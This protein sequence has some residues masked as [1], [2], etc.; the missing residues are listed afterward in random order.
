[1]VAGHVSQFLCQL[2][3]AT[4]GSGPLTPAKDGT[5][6]APVEWVGSLRVPLCRGAQPPPNSVS[7]LNYTAHHA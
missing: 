7:P 1:M 6:L 5:K 3:V 2:Q 4:P